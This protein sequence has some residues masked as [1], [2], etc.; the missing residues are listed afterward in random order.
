MC[1]VTPYFDVWNSHKFQ[2]S[3]AFI[4]VLLRDSDSTFCIPNN[5]LGCT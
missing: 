3:L 2:E 4:I 1:D 5:F